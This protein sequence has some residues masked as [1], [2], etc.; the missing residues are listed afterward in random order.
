MPDAT[1]ILLDRR[2]AALAAFQAENRL[3]SHI[4]TKSL[5]FH[6]ESLDPPIHAVLA[7][8]REYLDS[9]TRLDALNA[10]VRELGGQP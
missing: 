8:A 4:N 1:K 10:R 5:V 3:R 9:V 6:L 7:A 2:E